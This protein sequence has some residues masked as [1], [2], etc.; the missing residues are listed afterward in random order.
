MTQDESKRAAVFVVSVFPARPP[1][2]SG[3]PGWR[4]SIAAVPPPGRE[5]EPPCWFHS[6]QQVPG[7][8]RALLAQI[9]PHPKNQDRG[10]P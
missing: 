2:A 7:I 3:N 5:A 10:V 6:L 9:P 8:L 4:G 1:A